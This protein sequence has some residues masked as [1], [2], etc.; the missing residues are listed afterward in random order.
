[1]F[2]SLKRVLGLDPNENALKRYR[3]RVGRVNALEPSLQA[4]SD[5]ELKTVQ[6]PL[7]VVKKLLMH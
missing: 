4:L 3:S 6:L 7:N 5:E 2:E 1:M